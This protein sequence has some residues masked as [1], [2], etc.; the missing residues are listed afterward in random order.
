LRKTR[1]AQRP[2]STASLRSLIAIAIIAAATSLG[3][4][5]SATF[6]NVANN[7]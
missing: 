1:L 7:F 2:L 5:L 6:N 3:T 4:K